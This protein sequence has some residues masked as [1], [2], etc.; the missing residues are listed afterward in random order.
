[1][2]DIQRTSLGEFSRLY[3]RSLDAVADKPGERPGPAASPP[4]ASENSFAVQVVLG[5]A[6]NNRECRSEDRAVG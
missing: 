5:M 3:I 1:M 2:N 6:K 4:P